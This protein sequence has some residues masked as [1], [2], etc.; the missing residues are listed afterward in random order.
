MSTVENELI[1]GGIHSYSGSVDEQGRPHGYG[2]RLNVAEGKNK[3]DIYYG[4]FR[5]GYFHG[6]GMYVWRLGERHIGMWAADQLHGIGYHTYTNGDH[7]FGPYENLKKHGWGMYVFKSGIRFIGAWD[8]N[9]QHGSGILQRAE[10][11]QAVDYV[12]GKSVSKSIGM[13][14]FIR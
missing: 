14:L 12:H 13:S 7:Y 5:H 4:E 11:S 10:G 3:G 2:E 9:V 6:I 1:N 8:Q